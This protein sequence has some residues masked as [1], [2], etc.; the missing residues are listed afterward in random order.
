MLCLIMK[1]VIS[2]ILLWR[3]LQLNCIIVML[4]GNVRRFAV[5]IPTESN[6][7][8][9]NE[10]NSVNAFLL[11]FYVRFRNK[12]CQRIKK[13]DGVSPYIKERWSLLAADNKITIEGFPQ[14][15]RTLV[16]NFSRTYSVY[17][18]KLR[19]PLCS[20]DLTIALTSYLL[21]LGGRS[22]PMYVSTLYCNLHNT[23][24]NYIID[25]R[26]DGNAVNT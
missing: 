8:W 23:A 18:V 21:L 1:A 20:E 4:S 10:Y 2:V 22:H 6:R 17:I 13:C 14:S 11:W 24:T 9:Q 25:Y 16:G 7:I 5:L 3:P 26:S 15:Q 12:C 19:I